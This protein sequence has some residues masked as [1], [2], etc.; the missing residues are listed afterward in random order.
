MSDVILSFCRLET[1][2]VCRGRGDASR[3]QLM[4][5]VCTRTHARTYFLY[6]SVARNV[7]IRP[8]CGSVRSGRYAVYFILSH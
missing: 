6:R 5:N 8:L 2:S 7:L 4:E 1:E 3:G